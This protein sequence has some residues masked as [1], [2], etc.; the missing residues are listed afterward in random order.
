ME[1]QARLQEVAN[2]YYSTAGSH[3]KHRAVSSDEWQRRA[4]GSRIMWQCSDPYCS[5]PA[6]L[7]HLAFRDRN[8]TLCNHSQ[9]PDLGNL[10]IL[11][12]HGTC[13]APRLGQ[14][15]LTHHYEVSPETF[16]TL[17]IQQHVRSSCLR[18]HIYR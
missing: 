10:A 3:G 14:D 9:S 5:V 13:W 4:E 8:G 17:A 1:E 12:A 18:S 7:L 15:G 11:A 16:T 2:L 6:K